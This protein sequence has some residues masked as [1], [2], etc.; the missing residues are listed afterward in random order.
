MKKKRF[1]VE[2][3]VGILKQEEVRVPV[4]YQNPMFGSKWCCWLSES[5]FPKLLIIRGNGWKQCN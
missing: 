1:T 5:R 3:M 4:P 2:R